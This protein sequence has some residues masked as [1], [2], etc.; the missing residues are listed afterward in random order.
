VVLDIIP[1]ALNSGANAFTDLK[2]DLDKEK[3]I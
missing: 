2:V 3:A 1:D